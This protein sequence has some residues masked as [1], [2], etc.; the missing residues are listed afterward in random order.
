MYNKSSSLY[1]FK[2]EEEAKVETIVVNK[3]LE[4]H[5]EI[6][7]SKIFNNSNLRANMVFDEETQKSWP[8]LTIFVKN[9]TGEITGAKIISSEFKN[10]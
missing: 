7:S 4:N 5:T 3:Y 9:E 1:Y 2:Q 10:M 8:A 6:Y